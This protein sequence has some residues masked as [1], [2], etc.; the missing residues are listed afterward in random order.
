LVF[1]TSAAAESG[2]EIVAKSVSV[3]QQ[4]WNKARRYSFIDHEVA[5][6]RGASQPNKTERVLMIDGSPYNELVA[7]GGHA[8]SKEQQDAEARKLARERTK[9]AHESAQDRKRRI[10]RYLRERTQ[11]H[12]M[13][14]EMAN[15]FEYTV[16]GEEMLE[17]HKVW[18]IK[19]S[20]K[21][22]YVA[23]DREGRVLKN[24][25]GGL[26][27][28]QAT[29]QWVK[30]QAHVTRP[31]SMYGFLAKVKPGTRFELEQAP[32]SGTLW[33]PKRFVVTV[34]ATA[35]GIRNENS[36]NEDDFRDYQLQSQDV[37]AQNGQPAEGSGELP[38]Q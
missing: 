36:F 34:R 24:M 5:A 32:V 7:V 4:D 38:G 9:R 20:P 30:A 27:I 35:L 29:Y 11:D 12:R 14:A 3:T 2:D 37:Q 33:L 1:V 26:W 25:D 31:V 19:S 8:L 28:D 23:H 10:A 21:P 18:V 16:A 15:A 17:G 22:G 6:K 13:L